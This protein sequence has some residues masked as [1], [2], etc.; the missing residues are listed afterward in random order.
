MVSF[1]A[2]AAVKDGQGTKR[3]LKENID[4]SQKARSIVRQIKTLLSVLTSG[5]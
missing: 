5:R 1:I 4:V 2:V 3:N